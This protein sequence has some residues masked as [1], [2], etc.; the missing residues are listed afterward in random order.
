MC[1]R[2]KEDRINA[3]QAWKD[4]TAMINDKYDNEWLL[5]VK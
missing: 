5:N 4:I 1:S 2:S 3:E